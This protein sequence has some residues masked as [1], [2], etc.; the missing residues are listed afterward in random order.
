MPEEEP[1]GASQSSAKRSVKRSTL[2]KKRDLQDRFQ[3]RPSPLN[4]FL[5]QDGRQKETTTTSDNKS[6]PTKGLEIGL[7]LKDDYEDIID[8]VWSKDEVSL[9]L[10]KW[11]D[12]NYV[13]F[14]KLTGE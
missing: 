11:N 6:K 9:D 5:D 14:G 2:F 7:N 8:D 12:I 4:P 1:V 10:R 13:P 3:N